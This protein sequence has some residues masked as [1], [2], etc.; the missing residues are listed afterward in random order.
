MTRKIVFTGGGTGGHVT[1]A[2]A[3][4]EGLR[5]LYPE[6]TFRYV[7]KKGKVEEGMVPK[8]MGIVRCQRKRRFSLYP[9]HQVR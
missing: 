5:E 7:G 1:P 4:S 9:L 8:G 2:I 3:I 6:V